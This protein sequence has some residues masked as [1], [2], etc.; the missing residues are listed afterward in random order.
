MGVLKGSKPRAEVLAGDLDDAIFA[1]DFGKVI[2]GGAP[3]VYQDAKTFFLNTHPAVPLK[4]VVKDVFE[5]LA[6]AKENGATIRLS[7]GFGGGKTHTL[8]TL[9][10]LGKNID[11][12]SL[13]TDVL[14]AAGRPKNVRVVAIDCEKAGTTTFLRH[15]KGTVATHSLWGEVAYGLGGEKALK[16]LGKVDDPEEQ[17]DDQLFESL[18]PEGPVLILLDE[19]VVYMATLKHAAEGNLLVFVKKLISIVSSRPQTALVVTDPGNQQAFATQASRLGAAA[20][21]DNIQGRVMSDFDPIGADS[22]RV[23]VRR[24]FERVDTA[25]AKSASAGYHAFYERVSKEHPN[26][27]PPEATTQ[28]YAEAIVRSYP[29][30]PRLLKT[31]TDRLAGLQDFQRSRGALRLFARILRTVWDAKEDV[32]LITAGEIDWTSSRIQADLLDRLNRDAFKSAVS[33][34]IAGHAA[35]LDAGKPGGVHVRVA[36]AL[37][38]ESIPMQANDGLDGAGVTLAVARPEEAGSEPAEALDRLSGVCWHTYPLAGGIGLQFRYEPNINRQIEERMT[39][40]PIEDAKSRVVAE[41]IDYFKGPSFK[42]APFPEGARQVPESQELQLAI[43]DEEGLARRVCE[44]SDDSDPAAPIPRRFRNSIVA[45]SA[46][47]ASLQGAVERARRLIAAE[48]I[49]KEHRE[50]EQGKL[51]REQLKRVL[52]ELR[53][54]ARIQTCR[55]FDRV[56]LATGQVATLDEAYQVSEEQIL[57]KPQGQASIMKFLVEKRLIYREDDSVDSD[58]FLKEV[59]AGA[60]PVSGTADVYTTRAVQERFL[61]APKLRLVPD[62]S[63]VRATILKALGEKKIVVRLE[64]GRAY[65]S[66]GFVEGPAGGRKRKPGSL[67]TVGLEES[68]QVTPASSPSAK[69]WLQEDVGTGKAKS[70]ETPKPPRP[71]AHSA[72]ASSW[73]E[74]KS[75]A[76]TRPLLSLTLTALSPAAASSLTALSQPFGADEL[77]LEVTTGGAA[78]DGG[79]LNFAASG[80]KPSHGVKP[81]ILAQTV[82][83][84][85]EEGSSFEASL[86]LSFGKE[87]R[88]GLAERLDSASEAAAEGIS[89]RAEFGASVSGKS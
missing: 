42:P 63:V 69:A 49:E 65:D 58:L 84:A 22:A 18:F 57:Q 43:C 81:L 73:Q 82:F 33:A 34:D 24:L 54:H 64:G 75:L 71:S 50:G 45:V 27:I 8:L 30:H 87:G 79:T 28:T 78:R 19:L 51:T 25:A 4:K 12:H 68:T 17:P 74:A 85:L 83:N 1:A 55:A 86:H 5:R 26:L 23:I 15:E 62:G 35:E 61:S 47:K 89:M 59:L 3:K 13:G 11:D 39:K 40:V 37:L 46:S 80:L 77:V 76:A 53:K 10:H 72:S 56:V 32:E 6:N 70:G 20:K 2:A 29:F 21:L 67:G 44:F 60:T 52:P 41:A 31:C 16:K 38:L 66:A 48:A 88:T 14:P 36:S 7:T 9:W